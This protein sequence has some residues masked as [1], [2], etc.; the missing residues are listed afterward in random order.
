VI[1]AGAEFFLLS[2]AFVGARFL[3]LGAESVTPLRAALVV[4]AM[5]H[6]AALQVSLY[7]NDLY[8]DSAMRR[9]F[10][11]M[12]RIGQ[13][14]AFAALILTALY[15]MV[16]DLKVG[17][18]I[19][20]I[21]LPLA[22][23]VVVGWRS[24]YFWALGHEALVDNVLIL[25]TGASAQQVAREMVRRAH[26]GFKVVGFLGEHSA[27]VGKRLVNP[28]V[29]GTISDLLPMTMSQRVSL[30][31]VGL[32]DRRGKL[33]ISELLQCR[34]AGVRVEEANG[35]FERLTGRI[36]VRNLR[37]SWLVFSQGFNKPRFLRSSKRISELAWAGLMLL[38]LAPVMAIIALIVPLDS[39]GPVFYRQERC[40]EKGRTFM[41]LKFRT[42]RTD[43]EAASGPVWATAKGDA[44][45]TRVG[46]LLRRTRLD[47]LP[48]LLNVLKG[49]MSFVGPRPERPHFVEQ[50]RRIIPYYDERHS[51]KPGI[52]GWAQIKFGYGSTIED[53]EEK[54]Q[55]DLYYVK[56]M[57]LR[58]DLGILLDTFKVL[59]TGRGAR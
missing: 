17:R 18:G 39:I 22:T 50:L 51:V 45:T 6:A 36:I 8:E 21:Y 33:P 43:A 19:L 40:G 41:L 1:C 26:L 28:S 27:E 9:R 20:L 46:R 7:Y 42:M 3:R 10:E 38:V 37:P 24:I 35:L 2:A 29:I 14:I 30:I 12:A 57:S 23:L 56:H 32:D 4:T 5:L 55:Y 15:F 59:A 16:E 44:R 34:L 11:L 52:T 54:L 53:A 58:F 49:D 48:Q 13:A 47:E 25:G 31:V